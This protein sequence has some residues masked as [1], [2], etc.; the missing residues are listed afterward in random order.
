MDTYFLFGEFFEDVGKL[1]DGDHLDAL[2]DTECGS[3]VPQLGG[4]KLLDLLEGE[5]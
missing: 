2:L 5:V 1:T 3:V 4:A